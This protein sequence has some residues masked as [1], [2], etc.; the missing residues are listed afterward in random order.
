MPTTTYS[1]PTVSV[2]SI[3]GRTDSSGDEVP[4]YTAEESRFITEILEPGYL[5]PAE[6]WQVTA[7]D[8]PNMSVRVGSG[9]AKEDYYVVGGQVAGQG[10]YIV[11]LDAVSV[12]LTVPAADASQPR[13]DE[14][15]LVVLDNSYDATLRGLPQLGYRR[16]GLG[17]DAPGPDSAWEAYELL[18]S[19]NVATTVTEITD[20][21]ITDERS[22]AALLEGLATADHGSLGGLDGDD[23]P[24]YLTNSRGD[25]RYVRSSL[26]NSRGDLLVGTGNNALSR[27][28]LGDGGEVLR[29]DGTSAQWSDIGVPKSFY[30]T[31]YEENSTLAPSLIGWD[32]GVPGR[33][34]ADLAPWGVYSIELFLIAQTG[35]NSSNRL[36]FRWSVP[37]NVRGRWSVLSPPYSTSSTSGGVDY[38]AFDFD[39]PQ[40]TLGSSTYNEQI[41]FRVS[42][43]VL[44]QQGVSASL[45][46]SFRPEINGQPAYINGYSRMTVTRIY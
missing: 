46:P 26:V 3:G 33:F 17:G 41:G 43:T 34:V 45:I 6:A 2:A 37:S 18:G 24:Q 16:G 38:R 31:G 22:S 44:N 35:G 1:T 8:T 13:V 32:Y 29:S 12:T 36:V 40:F 11:R 15:Y 21:D 5:R 19:I 28:S 25:S 27:V 42:A 9:N 23:H 4:D 20:T 39:E 10:K 30:L 7:Q 14:V